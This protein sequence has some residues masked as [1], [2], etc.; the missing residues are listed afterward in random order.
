M[1]AQSS[2]QKFEIKDK[3]RSAAKTQSEAWGKKSRK[4]VTNRNE[5]ELSVAK[6][7][8][9]GIKVYRWK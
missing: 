3:S 7:R 5:V 4:E 1:R 2:G 8:K 9:A 6:S